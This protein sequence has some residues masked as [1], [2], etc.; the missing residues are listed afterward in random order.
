MHQSKALKRNYTFLLL[1]NS[2]HG[3]TPRAFFVMIIFWKNSKKRLTGINTFQD[4]TKEGVQV[5]QEQ[6]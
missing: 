6:F 1:N 3:P 5:S 4:T 2:F